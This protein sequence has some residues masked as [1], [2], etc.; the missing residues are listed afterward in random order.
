MSLAE[1]KIL[2]R[3]IEPADLDFIQASWKNS[4]CYTKPY[5]YIPKSIFYN[6]YSSVI[7]R[8]IGRPGIEI[9][10]A[11][12]ETEPNIVLGFVV[13]EPGIIHWIYVKEDWR[14]LGIAKRLMP[15][16]IK[17]S[18]HITELGWQIMPESIDY[19]PFI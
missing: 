14:R 2:V 7:S 18:S 12:L 10:S 13:Y 6:F 15:K 19:N 17:Y 4:L 1:A 11:V 8:I 5:R 16:G 3:D 9:K